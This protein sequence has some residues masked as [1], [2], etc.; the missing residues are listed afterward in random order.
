MLRRPV[1]HPV[2]Y[3]PL[4]GDTSAA[5]PALLLYATEGL[6]SAVRSPAKDTLLSHA[7]TR[8]GSGSAFG[9]HQAMDQ[10]GSSRG[11]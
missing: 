9:V 3:V 10:A 4:I 1:E 11:R 7:S 2:E 5:A 6:G 8:T